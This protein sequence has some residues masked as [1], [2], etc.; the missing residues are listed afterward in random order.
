VRPATH[1]III[2]YIRVRVGFSTCF[3][4]QT[5]DA[6]S[7]YG[8][9]SNIIY[10]HTSASWALDETY[11]LWSNGGAI[12]NITFSNNL[13]AE[14]LSAHSTVIIS[15]AQDTATAALVGPFDL[16]HN[17]LMNSS[18][19]QPLLFTTPVRMVNNIVYNWGFYATQTVG[20]VALDAINN[21]YKAGPIDP[22]VHEI[23]VYPGSNGDSVA[24]NPSIYVLGN[25][26][27]HNSTPSSDNWPMVQLVSSENGS[28]QGT[29]ST[30]YRRTTPLA[31]L[32][33]PIVPTAT[34]NLESAML[35]DVGDSARLDCNGNWVSN[36]D[37]VDLRLINDY[38]TGTGSIP[39]TENDVGGFPTIANGTPCADS[40]HDGMPDVW[41][42]A[43]GLNPNNAA[44]GNQVDPATGFTYLEDY[45]SGIGSGSTAPPPPPPPPSSSGV[46]I[47]QATPAALTAAPGQ[48]VQWTAHFSRYRP[49]PYHALDAMEHDLQRDAQSD[50]AGEY[51]GGNLQR[52]GRS[53]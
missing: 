51:A 20:G 38:Q 17:L 25:K 18:H 32:P 13:L 30:T 27:P 28:E 14:A 26:G 19:R 44:D 11:Q 2:R 6:I 41:E 37:T 4:D 3:P 24:G 52:N 12:T 49:L 29:L 16:H 22:G 50:G 31:A 43:H 45:L 46:T 35:Q 39:T 21:I 10:D 8:G 34:A 47:N 23:Q 9:V 42:T 40:D 5:G 33:I 36:R 48:N 7:L 1:D 15:G 53:F